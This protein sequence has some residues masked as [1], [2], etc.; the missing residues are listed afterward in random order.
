MLA[1][2]ALI[3]GVGSGVGIMRCTGVCHTSGDLAGMLSAGRGMSSSASGGPSSFAELLARGVKSGSAVGH[4]GSAAQLS[5]PGGASLL[6]AHARERTNAMLASLDT[7]TLAN[8]E[9]LRA[10]L[11]EAGTDMPGRVADPHPSSELDDPYVQAQ[12]KSLADGFG[13]ADAMLKAMSQ[14]ADE[15]Y[16]RRDHGSSRTSFFDAV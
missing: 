14:A 13:P 10:M 8:A 4:A 7:S 5:P 2:I 3:D 9:Q 12:L 16:A 1:P 11:T 15:R 6:A